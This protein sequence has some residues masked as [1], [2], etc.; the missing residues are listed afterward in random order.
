MKNLIKKI[1]KEDFNSEDFD[2]IRE[3]DPMD[4]FKEWIESTS[5][6]RKDGVG[7]KTD[8]QWLNYIERTKNWIEDFTDETHQLLEYVENLNSST[9]LEHTED[10]LG[11]IQDYIGTED[12]NSE[13]YYVGTYREGERYLWMFLK[14]FSSYG[15]KYNLTLKE[16]LD[17]SHKY[18]ESRVD[19]DIEKSESLIE[20]NELEKRS[21]TEIT[22]SLLNE[23]ADHFAQGLRL[24]ES[25]TQFAYDSNNEDLIRD[26]EELRMS[27]QSGSDKMWDENPNSMNIVNNINDIIR[28]YS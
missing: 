16:L 8:R 26:L 20:Y 23:A 5:L 11:V 19:S 15:K 22:I 24:I 28:K 1:L 25:A 2:W 7:A 10:I 4:T 3:I 13:G 17:I 6:V 27:I 9:G 18:F 21:T 12:G 14:Y